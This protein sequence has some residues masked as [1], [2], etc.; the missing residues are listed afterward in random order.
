M[1]SKNIPGKNEICD[2]I[3]LHFLLGVLKQTV[4]TNDNV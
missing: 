2:D 4:D 3:H 1:H